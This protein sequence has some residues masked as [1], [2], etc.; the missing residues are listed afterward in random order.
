MSLTFGLVVGNRDFFPGELARAGREEMI[1]V[2]E[3]KGFQ[4]VCPFS[5][6]YYLRNSRN[7]G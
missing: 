1:R 3:S 7:M 6:R 2:L 5:R 4:V